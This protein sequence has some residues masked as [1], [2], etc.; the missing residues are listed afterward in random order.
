MTEAKGKVLN[1]LAAII[2]AASANDTCVV[3][4]ASAAAT[5]IPLQLVFGITTLCMLLATQ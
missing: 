4:A 5:A 1:V 3:A 2:V